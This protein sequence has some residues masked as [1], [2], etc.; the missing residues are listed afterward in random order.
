[1][2]SPD[3]FPKSNNVQRQQHQVQEKNRRQPLDRALGDEGRVAKDRDGAQQAHDLPHE[4]EQNH[5]E[6]T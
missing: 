1:L 6:A 5:V 4:G 2:A 3:G